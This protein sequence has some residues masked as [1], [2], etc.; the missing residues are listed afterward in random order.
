MRATLSQGIV[1]YHRQDGLPNRLNLRLIRS[2]RKQYR[3]ETSTR[4]I[5]T[6]RTLHTRYTRSIVRRLIQRTRAT[7]NNTRTAMMMS[8]TV[9]IR[10]GRTP[11]SRLTISAT[12]R[13]TTILEARLLGRVLVILLQDQNG[14]ITLT[15]ISRRTMVLIR[16][17]K[18]LLNFIN[19]YNQTFT[20]NLTRILTTAH[21]RALGGLIITTNRIGS[22][23]L[24]VQCH[25][26][27]AMM[28]FVRPYVRT[29]RHRLTIIK[30]RNLSR[31][32]RC[33]IL[34]LLKKL[35]FPRQTIRQTRVI[36]TINLMVSRKSSHRRLAVTTSGMHTPQITSQRLN[37]V[38]TPNFHLLGQRC[39]TYLYHN[40]FRNQR[41]SIFRHGR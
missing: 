38:T 14:T 26:R 39:S 30:T 40:L 5:G 24:I 15:N 36:M 1:T 10:N 3:I 2:L 37:L 23:N 19:T 6:F 9:I 13:R 22:R 8:N 33:L 25:K 20:R 12:S 7:C 4:R 16:Q 18:D 17:F 31:Y 41:H 11:I 35:N 21:R 28:T 29:R 32:I 34:L 27:R